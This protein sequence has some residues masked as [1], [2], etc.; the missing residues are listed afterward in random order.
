[1]NCKDCIHFLVCFAKKKNEMIE[2]G[3]LPKK[4]QNDYVA[5]KMFPYKNC[6]QEEKKSML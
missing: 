6:G 5:E 1:M 4:G 3:M 2:K